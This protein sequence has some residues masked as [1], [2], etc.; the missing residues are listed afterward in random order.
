MAGDGDSS[1][2]QDPGDLFPGDEVLEAVFA[3]LDGLSDDDLVARRAAVRREFQRANVTV[4]DELVEELATYEASDAWPSSPEISSGD[5]AGMVGSSAGLL[6]LAGLTWVASEAVPSPWSWVLAIVTLGAVLL[7]A[8]NTVQFAIA[9][10]MFKLIDR[11]FSGTLATPTPLGKRFHLGLWPL[12][13][14][15][16]ASW[17]LNGVLLGLDQSQWRWTGI[18]TLLACIAVLAFSVKLR[19]ERVD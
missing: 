9:F 7:G 5:L 8:W 1:H 11:A 4:T 13:P 19:S 17:V 14:A 16:V 10:I 3:A 18:S 15:F 12:I 2:T 6:A